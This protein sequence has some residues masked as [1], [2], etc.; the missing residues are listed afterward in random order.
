MKYA[1]NNAKVIDPGSKYHGKKVSLLIDKGKIVEISND[2]IK[3]SNS[4]SGEGLHV[5]KGWTDL[6]VHLKDPGLEHQERIDYLLESAA[7]GGFTSILTLP[8]TQP[9]IEH[10]DQIKNLLNFQSDFPVDILPSAVLSKKAE[11][12][13][14]AELIDLNEAGA[15][16]FTDGDTDLKNSELL[17]HALLYTQKFDGII[18][19]HAEDSE[20]SQ[21]GQM[22]EGKTST[23]LGLKGIPNIAETSRVQRDLELLEHYG[24]RIHF[25]H[26]STI[27]SLD[28]IKKAKNK[29]LNVSCDISVHHLVFDES[30]LENYDTN[31]KLLPPLRGKKEVQAF[32]KYIKDGTIDAIVSDHNAKDE[33]SKNLEYDLA[34]FG[35]TGLETLFPALND[36]LGEELGLETFIACLTEGPDKILKRKRNSIQEGIDADLTLFA[37]NSKWQYNPKKGGGRPL[38]SPYLEADFNTRIIA[39]FNKDQVLVN[40]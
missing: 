28:L 9:V 1:I 20:I 24:G 35:V 25:S 17:A 5:S 34:D 26:I 4:F 11:G 22:N 14:L 32:Q 30:A 10:K 15:V 31:F 8:N 36:R 33:E 19:I 7:R 6:R 27:K 18:L 21:N 39:T 23:T 37:L 12:E 16:A 29:G 3:A 2:S 40:S 13:E 38:N